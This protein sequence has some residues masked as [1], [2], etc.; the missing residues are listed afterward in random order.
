MG[1]IQ[2]IALNNRMIYAGASFFH[3]NEQSAENPINE[4]DIPIQLSGSLNT[5]MD[6]ERMVSPIVDYIHT[7]VLSNESIIASNATT[8]KVSDSGGTEIIVTGTGFNGNIRAY[9]FKIFLNGIPDYH[10]LQVNFINT[11]TFSVMSPICQ[12][13][14]S[15]QLMIQKTETQENV[16]SHTL[17]HG[18]DDTAP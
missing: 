3:V 15:Y 18:I 12:H 8:I 16:Q 9:W 17:L 5:F 10:Q 2:A 4:T 1:K 7:I 11:T 6:K 13:G 14:Q